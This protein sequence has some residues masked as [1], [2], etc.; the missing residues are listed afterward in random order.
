MT[1]ISYLYRTLTIPPTTTKGLP[2]MA[3]IPTITKVTL[4]AIFENVDA[5]PLAGRGHLSKKDILIDRLMAHINT[6]MSVA[7]AK[8]DIAPMMES[9]QER[10]TDP[11]LVLGL[12][13]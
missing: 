5:D 6:S 9:V 10:T 11:V 2:V 7:G 12:K 13:K 8:N 1:M 3:H 4:S